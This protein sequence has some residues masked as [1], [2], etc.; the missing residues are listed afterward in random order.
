M[1]HLDHGLLLPEVT[2]DACDL[3]KKL[4]GAGIYPNAQT[5]TAE[6]IG[7]AEESGL[8]VRTWGVKKDADVLRARD[9]GASDTT[10]D[11]PI[12]AKKLLAE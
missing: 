6:Q 8:F 2:Q 5:I 4:G 11:W 1:P 10:V 9:S 12:R 3:V 7:L